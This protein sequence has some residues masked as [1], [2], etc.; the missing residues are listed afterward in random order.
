MMGFRLELTYPGIKGLKYL[1][2]ISSYIV[3]LTFIVNL[4]IH[5][6]HS[7]A[8]RPSSVSKK[9]VA[10]VG[11]VGMSMNITANGIQQRAKVPTIMAI[12]IVI[13]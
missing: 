2:A 3:I 9:K 5:V 7:I 12:M 1:L 8:L 11:L 13:L 10:A 4:P 6:I